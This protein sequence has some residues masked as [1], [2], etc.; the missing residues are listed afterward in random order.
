M[1]I[2]SFE[3]HS[4]SNVQ[5]ALE[6]LNEYGSDARVLAGGTDLVLALKAKKIRPPHVVNIVDI[7]DLDYI[8]NSSGAIRIGALAKHARITS[9]SLLKEHLSALGN[10]AGLIGSWQLRNVGTIGGNLCNASPSA[11]SAPP[12]LAAEAEAVVL[13]SRGE[14]RIPMK[15]F[16]VGPGT[17]RMKPTQLLKEI[18]I[19]LKQGGACHSVYLKLKRKKAVDLALVGVCVQ[20]QLDEVGGTLKSVT[21]A[22]GGVAPTPVRA[23][24]AEKMLVGVTLK[25]ALEM[26]PEVAEAAIAVTRPISDVRATAAYRKDMVRVYVSRAAGEVFQC[27]SARMEDQ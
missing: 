21:I 20:A 1:R 18:V 11:D 5:E 12:L 14:Y 6:F 13:D 3:Y 10:A 25:Q 19:P 8:S 26:L 16:F 23:D 24:E 7:P 2:R 15:D 27:L 17:T 4:C 9:S 22:L